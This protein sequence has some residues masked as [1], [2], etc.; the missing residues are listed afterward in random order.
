MD[1][2]PQSIRLQRR[3]IRKVSIMTK[4]KIGDGVYI[5]GGMGGSVHHKETITEIEV[6]FDEESGMPYRVICL[7]DHK[8]KASTGQPVTPPWAYGITPEDTDYKWLYDYLVDNTNKLLSE[9][10]ERI[11]NV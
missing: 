2:I 7:D 11:P 5:S 3:C 4:H 9:L 10:H 8:F 6:R 1:G